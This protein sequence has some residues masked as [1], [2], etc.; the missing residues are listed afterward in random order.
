MR[1]Y[2]MILLDSS[3]SW[4]WKSPSSPCPASKRAAESTTRDSSRSSISGLC[5]SPSWS[6][7]PSSMTTSDS[8]PGLNRSK[9]HDKKRIGANRKANQDNVSHVMYNMCKKSCQLNTTNHR[10]QN[11]KMSSFKF[12][13]R[14]VLLIISYYNI[15]REYH[16]R[17]PIAVI[18]LCSLAFASDFMLTL[19][20]QK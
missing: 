10:K 6:S 12:P 5:L 8:A 2:L 7:Q 9:S 20:V 14:K 4:S 17:V 13:F 3:G 18:S 11:M 16:N 15:N 1:S 19:N